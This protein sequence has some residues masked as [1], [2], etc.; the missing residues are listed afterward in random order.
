MMANMLAEPDLGIIPG[1]TGAVDPSSAYPYAG[2]TGV[3]L[4]TGTQQ[5]GFIPMSN[6][7]DG[8]IAGA[9]EDL[10]QWLNTPFTSNMSAIDV[11]LLVGVVAIAIVAWN[12]I[13]YHIRIASEAL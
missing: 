3:A 12:F 7:E 1:T 5:H 4:G 8:G 9:I 10:W 13:L 11:G 2:T 6:S